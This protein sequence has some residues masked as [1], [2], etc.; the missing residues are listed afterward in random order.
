MLIAATFSI[1]TGSMVKEKWLPAGELHHLWYNL[2]V[3][4][5]LILILCL[6]THLLMSAKI[7][8]LPFIL[9]MFDVQY[10]PEDSPA[11][12]LRQI[13]AVFQ[14]NSND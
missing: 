5:W 14:R 8:G 12:W 1:V 11:T 4:G 10:Q 7:G 13:R 2:H 9:S 6:A 3:L